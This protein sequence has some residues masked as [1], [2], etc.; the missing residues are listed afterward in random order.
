MIRTLIFLVLLLGSGAAQATEAGWAL[1]REGGHVV[2]LRHAAATAAADPDN[3]TADDCATQRPLSERGRQQARKMGALFSARAE[4]TDK[5]MTS[6]FCRCAETAALAF[7]SSP[8]EQ[9]AALD[10]PAADEAARAKQLDEIR[11]IIA[12][13]QGSGNLVLVT[14]LANIQA[15]TG[16]N[17]RE[18][19]ALI[20][21]NQGETVHV[22]ARIVV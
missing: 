15:L 10:P 11:K 14:H 6:R 17:A 1:L 5:V 21:R 16:V 20:V 4:R 12:G 3:V 7:R 8:V 2:L 19:E 9:V 18:G 13:W 22:L